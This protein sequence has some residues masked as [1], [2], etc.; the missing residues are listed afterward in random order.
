MAPLRSGSRWTSGRLLAR[1]LV[2][3]TGSGHQLRLRAIYDRQRF[4]PAAIERLLGHLENILAAMVANPAQTL[5][6][7]SLLSPAERQQL[8]VEWNDTERPVS[9][10]WRRRATT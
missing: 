6:E 9:P 7:I 1:L 4:E 8:L 5:D 2:E 10:P 3:K